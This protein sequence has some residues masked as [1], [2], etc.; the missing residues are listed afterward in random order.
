[1]SFFLRRIQDGYKAY[2]SSRQLLD[3]PIRTHDSVES[4]PGVVGPSHVDSREF[5]PRSPEPL[6]VTSL[7]RTK[8]VNVSCDGDACGVLSAG[9]TVLIWGKSTE[10]VRWLPDNIPLLR[11]AV[12][13]LAQ[14]G[15][16]IASKQSIDTYGKLPTA[17]H[18]EPLDCC[19]TSVCVSSDVGPAAQMYSAATLCV[20]ESCV[21]IA[22]Q[23]VRVS[24]E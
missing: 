22:L 6:L 10:R 12:S 5:L 4:L 17:V 11:Q 9:G 1:V 2:C 18:T 14:S 19:A 21:A 23:R 7:R 16:V 13:H 8:A 24:Q 15:C 20:S 3:A